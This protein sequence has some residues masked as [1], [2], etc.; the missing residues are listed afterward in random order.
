MK[1]IQLLIQAKNEAS[2]QLK[3]VQKDLGSMNTAAVGFGK[4]AKAGF[5]AAGVAAAAAVAS[6]AAVAASI[7]QSADEIDKLSQRTGVGTKDLQELGYAAKMSD[8]NMETLGKSLQIL[9]KNVVGNAKDFKEMGINVKDASG[10]T[11]TANALFLEAADKISGMT[12]ETE[13][14]AASMKLFG[15]SGAELLPMLNEGSAA[16]KAQADEANKL[17]VVFSDKLI[18]AADAMN[19]EFDKVKL[20]FV[21]LVATFLDKNDVFEKLGEAFSFIKEGVIA[22]GEVF[23]TA[24]DADVQPL[25]DYTE[26]FKLLA[27]TIATFGF[28]GKI[29]YESLKIAFVGIKGLFQD[30]VASVKNSSRSIDNAIAGTINSAMNISARLEA[31]KVNKE[32]EKIAD[33][34]DSNLKRSVIELNKEF[35]NTGAFDAYLDKYAELKKTGKEV[36]ADLEKYMIRFQSAVQKAVQM[37]GVFLPDK[38]KLKASWSDTFKDFSVEY[39]TIVR[40]IISGSAD[41]S[42]AVGANWEEIGRQSD[43]GIQAMANSYA[44][45]D[46]VMAR[47]GNIKPSASK[48]SAG[49][50]ASTG[51]SVGVAAYSGPS[52]GGA[53]GGGLESQK[54]RG[55]ALKFE[56]AANEQEIKSAEHK[57]QVLSNFETLR[58]SVIRLS[59]DERLKLIDEEEAATEAK[60]KEAAAMGID[61]ERT[62]TEALLYYAEERSRI[63]MDEMSQAVDIASNWAN[64]AVSIANNMEQIQINNANNARNREIKA[65][66]NSVLSAKEKEEKI[67]EIN[68][69]ADEKIREEK[70]KQQNWAIA[71][72]LISG[73]VASMSNWESAMKLGYPANIIVGAIGQA[74]IVALTATEVGVIASQEF[75]RGGVVGGNPALGDVQNAKLTGGEVVMN[76]GQQARTL[77]AIANG[78]G[79]RGT[80]V[81]GGDIHVTIQGNADEATINRAMN[82]S[83]QQ[84]MQDMKMLLRDMQYAGLTRMAVA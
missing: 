21:G 82:R 16:I 65:V 67:G 46:R 41:T 14:V 3:D 61:V 26:A 39:Q 81:R 15:K 74:L 4:V 60:L 5:A 6:F 55:D 34:V 36:P 23:N 12:N 29:A 30:L 80:S 83:R 31:N 44:E 10:N 32:L 20:S 52:L 7:A 13:K 1:E 76:Q 51:G 72:A 40:N 27:K 57:A 28:A 45:L 54:L 2:K 69:K 49:A 9:S 50:G 17:G 59:V 62:H 48:K 35:G 42:E 8:V 18:S 75:A 38:S 47:I 25:L 66:E 56:I 71:S 84:Q 19:D 53:S 24:G 79:G 43:A 22:A 11:K 58:N 63:R 78:S 64:T 37:E 70:K 77:M 33:S 73:A 68:K